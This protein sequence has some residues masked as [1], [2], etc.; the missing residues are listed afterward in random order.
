MRIVCPPDS[1]SLFFNYKNFFSV[2]LLAVIDANYKFMFVDVGSYGKE[3]DSGIFD[4]SEL[5]RKFSSGDMFPPPQKL[6]KT[7]VVLPHVFVG[8]EAF[9]LHPNMMKPYSKPVA[10]ADKEKAIF[11][12][13][14]S[15]ARRVSENAFGLASKVFRVFYTPI[16]LKPSTTDNLIVVACCLHNLLRDAYLES[17]KKPYYE[18]DTSQMPPSENFTA[19]ARGGGFANAEGFAVRDAFTEYFNSRAGQVP[20]QSSY[21]TRTNLGYIAIQ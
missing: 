16:A 11:N 20:W 13:R 4:K 8:D 19:L 18:M 15:R 12:Y 10:S 5:G 14:L 9:R 1:G 21:V 2:V 3:G 17:N 7:D 6:P